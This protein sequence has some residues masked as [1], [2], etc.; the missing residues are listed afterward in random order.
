MPDQAGVVLAFDFGIKRIGVAMGE[1]MLGQA[2]A[3]GTIAEEANAP[4]FAAIEAL[5]RQWQPV[6]LVVGL[7]LAEDGGDMGGMSARARRFA[8]Q[9]QGRFGLTVTLVDERY[10]SIAAESELKQQGGHWTDT[11]RAVDATAARIILQGYFDD[12]A[13]R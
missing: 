3:L 9:L 7:P 1:A 8:N 11:R 4:R 5:I 6:G 10:S 12:I 13:R 2:R